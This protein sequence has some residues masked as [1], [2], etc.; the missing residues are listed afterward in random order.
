[1]SNQSRNLLLFL[2][3]VAT[4]ATLGLLF[5]PD[6]G[7]NTRNRLRAQLNGYIDQ[8]NELLRKEKAVQDELQQNFRDLNAEDYQRAE[9]LLGEVE[10]LLDEIRSKSA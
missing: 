2:G 7:S 5:A 1:M 4:G 9:E 8:L 6:S 3:G 10:G